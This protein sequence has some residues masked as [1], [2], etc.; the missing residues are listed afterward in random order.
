[1]YTIV[2]CHK[3]L[4][5]LAYNN[6]VY[7]RWIAGHAG[8]WRDE[9]ADPLA[10][11]GTSCDNLLPSYM[12]PAYIKTEINNKVKV[13]DKAHWTSNKHKHTTF[14]LGSKSEN[15]IKT[16]NK[17]VIRNKTRY[18]TAIH[19]IT[20]HAGLNKH[21]HTMTLSNTA[22]CPYCD[23]EDDAVSHFTGQCPAFMRLR[24]KYW[25]VLR[26]FLSLFTSKRQK[27]DRT[28]RVKRGQKSA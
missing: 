23:N 17:D 4:N 5:K 21:L 2:I 16:L 1:M 26:P 9:K 14:I 6:K 8:H 11:A 19:L 15:I 28:K 27:M 18:R 12:P 24:G 22:A 7:L 20:G 10:K 13:L 25:G 3:T